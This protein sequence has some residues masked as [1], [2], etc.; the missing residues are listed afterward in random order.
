MPRAKRTAASDMARSAAAPSDFNADS[1]PEL[2]DSDSEDTDTPADPNATPKPDTPPAPMPPARRR[3]VPPLE[4]VD[5]GTGAQR[6][7]IG[8]ADAEHARTDA[9][10]LCL[11]SSVAT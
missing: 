4:V 1:D 5:V 10:A 7:R 9:P 11:G 8:T 3:S 6:S 2:D